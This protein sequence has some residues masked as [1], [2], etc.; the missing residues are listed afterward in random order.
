M[1]GYVDTLQPPWP[2]PE[3]TRPSKMAR[4]HMAFWVAFLQF[5]VIGYY[6]MGRSFAY[7]GIPP[8][9]VF[10]GE[11]FLVTFIFAWTSGF[12]GVWLTS[13]TRSNSLTGFAWA[14]LIFLGYGLFETLRGISLG[15]SPAVALM[16]LVFNVYPFYIFIGFWFGRQVPELLERLIPRIGLFNGLYGLA[17]IGG[18]SHMQIFIPGSDVPVFGQPG[19]SMAVLLGLIILGRPG[20][21][22]K[23]LILINALVLLGTQI[24]GDWVGF[25]VALVVW[26]ALTGKLQQVIR[27]GAV[28]L[29]I[30][31]IGFIT[32]VRLPG[33][34]GRGGETSV[35][36]IIG[37]AMAGIDKDTAREFSKDVDAYAG[38]LSWRKN[39]WNEIWRSVHA[40]TE[41]TFLGLGYG[42]PLGSLVTYLGPGVVIRSPHSMFYYA[43]GFG[44]WVGLL[45]FVTVNL[46]ILRSLWR[47]Y[48]QTGFSFGLALFV[49][50]LTAASAGNMLETPFGAIPYYALMGLCLAHQPEEPEDDFAEDEYFEETPEPRPYTL[51]SVTRLPDYSNFRGNE[52][53]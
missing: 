24:R 15:Y 42:F 41:N 18:L 6:S 53:N 7:L 50:T 46:M 40:T 12:F 19:G 17:F 49:G 9:K 29:T 25:L 36:D 27:A 22:T 21:Y 28:L 44:G 38:T 8:A 33:V 34:A 14:H 32:D 51:P 10:I 1:T 11:I 2:T 30:L 13:L 39:W 43:L 26:G 47:N 16:N 4:L 45:L 23:F 37:R 48:R 52:L 35:R 31:L 5:L 3:G 20:N